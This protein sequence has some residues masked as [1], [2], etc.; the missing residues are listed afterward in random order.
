MQRDHII[1]GNRSQSRLEVE[2]GLKPGELAPGLAGF[3]WVVFLLLC[4][5][6]I[7]QLH[8]LRHMWTRPVQGM[9]V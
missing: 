7:S 1:T 4:L 2:R 5:L 8:I 9:G 3:I 6:P